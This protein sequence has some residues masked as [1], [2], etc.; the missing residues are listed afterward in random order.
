M[1]IKNCKIIFKDGIK[2][3]SIL[4]KDGKISKINPKKYDDE[5]IDAKGL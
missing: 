2:N 1:I 5:I 3:G 4:I